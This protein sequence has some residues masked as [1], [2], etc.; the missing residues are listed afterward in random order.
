MPL[1][2][3]RT[4]LF[5]IGAAACVSGASGAAAQPAG[6]AGYDWHLR[7]DESDRAG[8]AILAYEKND[9]DGQEL[10]FTCE[11]GGA[12]IFAGISGGPAGLSGIT[13][14]AGTETLRL[15]GK[16]VQT[17]IPEL[18][19]FTSVE[20]A[21]DHPFISA[22]AANGGLTAIIGSASINM[23]GTKAGTKAVADFVAHCEGR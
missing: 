19:S 14:T 3:S 12:R 7:I 18:P 16:T 10:N 5:L 22:L 9:T 23:A 21:G 1:M 2:T 17:E 11:A 6:K 13:L 8:Q 20:I 4:A 15:S